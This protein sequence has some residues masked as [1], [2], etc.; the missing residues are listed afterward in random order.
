MAPLITVELQTT[1]ASDCCKRFPGQNHWTI[2][3]CFSGYVSHQGFKLYLFV[4]LSSLIS[5]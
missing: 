4:L 1:F 3:Y 2:K 5:Q